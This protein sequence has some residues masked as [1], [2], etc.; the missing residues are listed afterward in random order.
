[1]AAVYAAAMR[2]PALLLCGWCAIGC[3]ARSSVDAGEG[4]L[5]GSG[6]SG[7]TAEV[8]G[9]GGAGAVGPSTT[10]TTGVGASGG[11]GTGGASP[12]LSIVEACVVAA[13]CGR[14][15]GWNEFTPSVCVDGFA[16]LGWRY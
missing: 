4:G 14:D 1:M 3:G 7:G 13:S 6:A 8:G 11:A 12:G 5:S 2:I 9:A 16:R 10:V 15:G